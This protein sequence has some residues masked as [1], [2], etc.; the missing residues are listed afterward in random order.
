MA[1]PNPF[2]SAGGYTIGI[3]PIPLADSNGNVYGNTATFQHL[4]ING[5][6]NIAGTLTANTF[7]GTFSGNISGGLTVPG[8]TNDVIFNSNGNAATSVNFTFD[9]TS[10]TLATINIQ[11]S[12]ITVGV[13]VNQFATT[14]SFNASTTSSTANQ[15]LATTLGSNIS[16]I[17][18]T[19]IAT[20]SL[21]Q[22]RQSSKLMA[23]ILSGD[24]EYYEFGTIDI[25]SD[26]PGVAD[27]KVVYS[28]GNVNLLV[29]PLFNN[30][31]YKVMTTV[32]SD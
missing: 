32:Y 21:S 28:G 25:P 5:S 14:T 26:S 19:I 3:P 7:V 18:Y 12:S 2:N 23:A 24:V 20:D 8:T 1:T 31:T 30:V 22:Y 10:N 15:V 13:G 16:G 11:S 17:D 6:A 4:V 27:F 29:T 9:Q